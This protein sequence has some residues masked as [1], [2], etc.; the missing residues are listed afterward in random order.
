M[1]HY[2]RGFAAQ[3]KGKDV[4]FAMIF[5]TICDETILNCLF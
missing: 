4:G 1:G 2:A 3:K 5:W